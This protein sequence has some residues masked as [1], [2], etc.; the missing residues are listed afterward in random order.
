MAFD[1][2]AMIEQLSGLT[3][4]EL[5]DLVEA[6]KEQW[7]VE[8]AMAMPLAPCLLWALPPKPLLLKSKPNSR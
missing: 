7:G 2:D 3:V 5:V 1:K 4:L 6:L 8:A